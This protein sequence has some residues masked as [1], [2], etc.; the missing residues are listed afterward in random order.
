MKI[1]KLIFIAIITIF[2]ISSITSFFNI[3]K[4]VKTICTKAKK[5]YNNN[6]TNSLIEII[7]S[8]NKTPQEK[9][10]AI[11]AL[12]QLADKKALPFLLELNSLIPK[13]NES[14]FHDH[15]SKYE[16]EKAIKWCTKG[17]ITSWMYKN[18]EKW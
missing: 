15:L 16:I 10:K 13:Q 12:G 1:V 5:E 4:S 7:K 14:N 3:Y 6:C 18:K 11:W 8:K 17:N 2:I 9:N